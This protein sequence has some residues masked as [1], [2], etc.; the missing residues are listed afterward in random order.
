MTPRMRRRVLATLPSM[1]PSIASNAQEVPQTS[2]VCDA[3][4][5]NFLARKRSGTSTS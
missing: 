2:D 1:L 4:D 3:Q 5:S